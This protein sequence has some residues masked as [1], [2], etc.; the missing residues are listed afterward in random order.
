MSD[1]LT[2]GRKHPDY[3]QPLPPDIKVIELFSPGVGQRRFRRF[4]LINPTASPYQI[5]WKMK[6]DGE[7]CPIECDTPNAFVSSGKR[8][9]VSFSE[10]SIS[11]KTL[12]VQLEFKILEHG[13]L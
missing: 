2:A 6:W 8:H 4:E 11:V 3:T 1:Y 5:T 7:R 13:I 12:E 9:S 10:T